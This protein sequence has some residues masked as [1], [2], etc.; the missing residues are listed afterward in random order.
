MKS[1]W[2]AASW[3]AQRGSPCLFAA[4]APEYADGGQLLISFMKT[5]SMEQWLA[6]MGSGL[7][8][9]TASHALARAARRQFSKFAPGHRV[10]RHAGC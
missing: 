5:A 7:G 1:A 3:R 4:S 6:T 10:H 9:G 2:P 8:V